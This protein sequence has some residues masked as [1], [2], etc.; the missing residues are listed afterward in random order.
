MTSSR[1]ALLHGLSNL[2]GVPPRDV[3]KRIDKLVPDCMVIGSA[4]GSMGSMENSTAR[5][6]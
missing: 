3:A 4:G 2:T 6:P 1:C 5:S